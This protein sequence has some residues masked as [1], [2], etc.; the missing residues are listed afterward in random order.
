M[1]INEIIFKPVLTE[2]ATNLAKDSV[3]CFEVNVKSNKNM[4]KE[5]IAKIFKV[6]IAWVKTII[7]KG[8][9]RKVGRR[10]IKKKL[11]QTKLALVK[12]KEGKIDLFPQT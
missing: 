6:K 3:Y 1:K 2:K 12:V 11:A 9:I 5:S 10:M 7:R 4:I 8:K